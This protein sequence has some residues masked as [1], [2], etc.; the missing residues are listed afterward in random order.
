VAGGLLCFF[1]RKERAR[2]RDSLQTEN[3]P[4]SQIPSQHKMEEMGPPRRTTQA[5][6]LSTFAPDY[7]R[8]YQQEVSR[9]SHVQPPPYL[10][11]YDPSRY[12]PIR[13]TSMVG[14]NFNYVHTQDNY[15]N[16]PPG[17]PSRLSDVH[18]FNNTSLSTSRPLSIAVQPAMGP[19]VPVAP[20]PRRQG[21]SEGRE[22]SASEPMLSAQPVDLRTKQPK[23][24]LS[25]LIT[26]FR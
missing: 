16:P 5:R 17:P 4:P 19:T 18:Y 2:K 12:Q 15:N 6:P 7:A 20:R 23:P 25:R 26:N 21:G 24:V 8:Q 14:N 3:Y 9:S 10:P 13:P 22:R 11:T 1:S